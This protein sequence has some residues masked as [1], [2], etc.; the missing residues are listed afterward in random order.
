MKAK[1]CR[2]ENNRQ[3]VGGNAR[4][5]MEKEANFLHH[6]S[7]ISAI[8]LQFCLC[9]IS[10]EQKGAQ[11][12]AP[13][14]PTNNLEPELYFLSLSQA[15]LHAHPFTWRSPRRRVLISVSAKIVQ[16]RRG[17]NKACHA[18]ALSL[19]CQTV[20]MPFFLSL[21]R[22]LS[23]SRVISLSLF[24]DSLAIYS[25]QTAGKRMDWALAVKWTFSR[26]IH[27]QLEVCI[28]HVMIMKHFF[29]FLVG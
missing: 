20:F 21:P 1:P 22:T 8:S 24:Y 7:A 29:V 2:R 5:M 15:H 4:W 27:S 19:H 9:K 26:N 23:L 11:T 18:Q 16:G 17:N 28:T 25:H 13:K 14:T 3:R 10:S 6:V 12:C